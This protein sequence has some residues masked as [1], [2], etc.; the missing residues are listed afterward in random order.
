M[1][2][3]NISSA[4]NRRQILANREAIYHVQE[5]IKTLENNLQNITSLLNEVIENQIGNK[6]HLSYCTASPLSDKVGQERDSNEVSVLL[7]SIS[8]LNEF[9]LSLETR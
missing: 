1:L 9:L 3:I 5:S 6:R 2:E 4:Y 8:M 7:S